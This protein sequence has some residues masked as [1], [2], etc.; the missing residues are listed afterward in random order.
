MVKKSSWQTSVLISG[1]V[2]VLN[3]GFPDFSIFYVI[4]FVKII[5]N[6]IDVL[7]HY[8]HMSHQEYEGYLNIWII[9]ISVF[10]HLIIFAKIMVNQVGRCLESLFS[11]ISSRVWRVSKHMDYFNFSIF[12]SYYFVKFSIGIS[13][14]IDV[15]K[16]YFHMSHQVL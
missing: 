4:I 3:K 5:I 11:H 7:N 15:L 12:S 16:R 9:S 14:K 8:F 6:Q 13:D 1:Q 2:D 10:F